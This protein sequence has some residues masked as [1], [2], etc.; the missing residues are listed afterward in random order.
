MTA[1]AEHEP[2]ILSPEAC[3]PSGSKKWLDTGQQK[4]WNK[5][6]G[7]SQHEDLGS[8]VRG[9][10]SATG[11][12]SK[13]PISTGNPEKALSLN[14][15]HQR[16]SGR[17]QPWVRKQRGSQ[18]KMHLLQ[19]TISRV[20]HA[21]LRKAHAF[22]VTKPMQAARQ[23]QHPGMK[24]YLLEQERAIH[25]LLG[26]PKRPFQGSLQ[27]LR[28]YLQ[29]QLGK[30]RYSTHKSLKGIH[31]QE[32]RETACQVDLQHPGDVLEI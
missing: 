4:R 31:I 17:L 29:Y 3:P 25:F 16:A 19:Q 8:G 7:H 13:V 2:G 28:P 14:L 26:L 1:S 18:V 27:E 15:S 5:G 22:K 9:P 20:R 12:S 23:S 10:V 24:F 32:G 6:R 11:D 21:S 30:K